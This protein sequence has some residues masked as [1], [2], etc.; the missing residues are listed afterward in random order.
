[1]ICARGFRPL[2]PSCPAMAPSA[3]MMSKW[4]PDDL[5]PMQ[6]ILRKYDFAALLAICDTQLASQHAATLA[7][8][9][10]T[11]P[12]SV[13]KWMSLASEIAKGAAAGVK[14]RGSDGE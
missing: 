12:P 8:D 2:P 1:M 10:Y 14:G 3:G 6:P 11:T 9:D 5:R 4:A 7:T 13:R